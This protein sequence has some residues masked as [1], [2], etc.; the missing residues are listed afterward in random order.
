MQLQQRAAPVC[1][2]GATA[3]MFVVVGLAGCIDGPQAGLWSVVDAATV[4]PPTY[5]QDWR[6]HDG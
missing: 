5:P 6:Q 4:P 3:D 1:H 2:D